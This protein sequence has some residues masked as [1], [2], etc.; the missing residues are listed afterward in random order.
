MT[1]FPRFLKRFALIDIDNFT[2]ADQKQTYN[3]RPSQSKL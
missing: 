1:K 3:Y 2:I